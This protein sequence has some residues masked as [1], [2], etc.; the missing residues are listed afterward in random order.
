MQVDFKT[1]YH[2]DGT[3]DKYKARLVILGC[4]QKYGID[5]AETFAPVAKLTTVRTLLVVAAMKNWFTCQMD[6]SNAF[7]HGELLEDVYM[8]M[9][10]GYSHYGSRIATNSSSIQ[11][12]VALVY[13][14]LKSL[15]GLKQAPRQWFAK[16]SSTLIHLGYHQSK[17]DYSLF[18]HQ[19]STTITLVLVYVD[20][21]LICGNFMD[22]INSLKKM[23]SSTFHM[24]D[25]G[26]LRYFLGLE[27]DRNDTG[28]FSLSTQI[29]SGHHQRKWSCK[30]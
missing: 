20:D 2:P 22:T 29:H 15:Y 10:P 12:S 30:F 14:L 25:L 6:V 13:K 16:L 11:A 4:H 21:L 23:L 27:V 19:N 28:I 3:I 8:K 7:L 5:Y 9:P 17:T 1:K 26:S 24:K 18:I